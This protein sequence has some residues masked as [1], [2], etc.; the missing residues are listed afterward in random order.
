VPKVRKIS[1]KVEAKSKDLISSVIH[2]Q[3]K[4]PED[5]LPI[6]ASELQELLEKAPGY[7]RKVRTDKKFQ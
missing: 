2:T 5:D 1:T 4:L 6:L 3:E 7:M